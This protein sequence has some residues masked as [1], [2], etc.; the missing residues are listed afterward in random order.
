MSTI[1]GEQDSTC[2]PAS[3]WAARHSTAPLCNTLDLHQIGH[4]SREDLSSQKE[5]SLFAPPNI[6]FMVAD[7]LGYNDVSHHG[8]R[9]IPTPSI[10]EIANTGISL[11]NYH[12]QPVCSP[13]RASLLSGRHAIHHGIY[14]PFAQVR[15]GASSCVHIHSKC[16]TLAYVGWSRASDIVGNILSAASARCGEFAPWVCVN[17][18]LSASVLFPSA[19]SFRKF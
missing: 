6:L 19:S 16:C 11:T 18:R 17:E 2:T 13:T 5:A 8:S 12:V 7:D 10:D 14:M 15:T 1:G 3:C 9:Q 4:L